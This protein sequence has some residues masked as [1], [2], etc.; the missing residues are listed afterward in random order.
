MCECCGP[1]RPRE[2]EKVE[3]NIGEQ[4]K[5]KKEPALTR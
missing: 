4:E 2:Q 3:S 5:A 1:A